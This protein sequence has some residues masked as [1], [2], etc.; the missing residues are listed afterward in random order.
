[1][2]LNKADKIY[3]RVYLKILNFL[4][5]SKRSTNEITDKIGKYL[6]KEHIPLREKEIIKD[7]V[8]SNLK[9]DGYIKETTDYDYSILYL[10]SLKKSPKP[11]N[12]INIRRFLSKKGIS[13]EIIADVLENLDE[14]SVYESVLK[15]AKKS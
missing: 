3:S 9:S 13:E 5:F 7:K 1:M 6:F 2:E 11:F 10:D 15:D 4:S 12:A 8:I 14:S